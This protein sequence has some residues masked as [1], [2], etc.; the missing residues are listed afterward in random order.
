LSL[1]GLL[2]IIRGP[3]LLLPVALIAAGAGAGAHEGCFSAVNT[4][5]ALAGLVALHVAV[6]VF[7]EIADFRTGIDLETV[8]TP[9]S[10]GSGTLPSGALGTGAAYVV[11]ALAT[12]S[13][14]AAGLYF[15]GLY[16]PDLV[17]LL[18]VGA[19]CVLG[20][21]D[22]FT[23]IGL[24]ELAAGLG[25]GGLAVWGAAFVQ[26]GSAGKTALAAAVPAFLMTFD[27]LL[28]NE[29]PDETADR[30]GG[31]RNLVLLLGRRRA[32]LVW[33]AAAVAAPA[34]ILLAVFLRWLP[35][36][37]IVAAL[38]SLVLIPGLRWA[39][40]RPETDVPVPALGANVAWNLTTNAVLAATLFL[41]R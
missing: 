17:P 14:L 2:G 20:Y 29:F 10:G 1:R 18:G 6:N 27:L 40:S 5:I 28:L 23:R 25:L 36:P 30:H 21:S 7:N 41:S 9:F 12:A 3:F 37:A 15:L 38:P 31:R 34:V 33:A 26:C 11:G 32:A 19:L 4:V 8:R 16:G 24:G 39:T 22:L 35:G 13:G